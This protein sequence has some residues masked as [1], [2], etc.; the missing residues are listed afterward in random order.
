MV[1]LLLPAVHGELRPRR[2]G[3]VAGPGTG[4]DKDGI[5]HQ[6]VGGLS[7]TARNRRTPLH[8]GPRG[9]GPRLVGLGQLA[10]L[11]AL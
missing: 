8:R 10:L 2:R 4:D 11:A 7:G 1:L 6:P 3:H 9:D 5:P